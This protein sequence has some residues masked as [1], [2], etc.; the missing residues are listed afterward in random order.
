MRDWVKRAEVLGD[1]ASPFEKLGLLHAQ[2]E[3][4][5]P[6]LDGNGRAGRLLMNLLLVR[7]GYAPAIV[8]KR[9]RS[10]YLRA[11]R[12]ADDGD[13]GALGERCARQYYRFPATAKNAWR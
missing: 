4:I 12:A 10:R 5:H 2:F 3:R 13:P 7:L 9:D 11:L 1:A 6:F 8:Y